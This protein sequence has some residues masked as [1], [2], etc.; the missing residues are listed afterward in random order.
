L[1]IKGQSQYGGTRLFADE[2]A[3]AFNR[4]G[5]QTEV[6]DL[7]S[8]ATVPADLAAVASGQRHDLVLTFNILG[9]F[10]SPSGLTMEEL[11][12]CPHVVW[13]TDYVLTSWTRLQETPST[14]LLLVVDPTQIGA[15]TCIGGKDRF[16]ARFFP[17]PAVGEPVADE[18]DVEAFMAQRPIPVLWSGGFVEPS[19]PWSSASPTT[20]QVM[21][22]AVDLRPVRRVDATA[23]RPY[24]NAGRRRVRCSGSGQASQPGLCLGG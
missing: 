13:H 14:T 20:Q 11:F 24:P 2:A 3:S 8:S 16:R 9:D 5:Y 19:R 1:V 12:G 21:D 7:G 15:L 10:R 23:R 6:L 17:H 4:L 18:P 22:G